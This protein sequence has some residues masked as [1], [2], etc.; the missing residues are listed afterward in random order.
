MT[1]NK[2][3]EMLAAFARGFERLVIAGVERLRM[4]PSQC[5]Q[6]P[7]RKQL[8]TPVLP[9]RREFFRP[10]AIGCFEQRA[11]LPNPPAGGYRGRRG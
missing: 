1:A 4:G 11:P 7:R 3:A 2:G 5:E 9:I 8:F 6:P 10:R